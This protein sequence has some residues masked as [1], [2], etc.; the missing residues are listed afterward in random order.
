MKY[1][2]RNSNSP[3]KVKGVKKKKETRKSVFL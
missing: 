3:A 1:T 2:C